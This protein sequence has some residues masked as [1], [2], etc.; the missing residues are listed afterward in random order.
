LVLGKSSWKNGYA[1]FFQKIRAA[2]QKMKLLENPEG[3]SKYRILE[4]PPL[5]ESYC[6]DKVRST[7]RN[8]S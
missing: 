2:S 8:A 1:R 7:V 3:I 5:I 6:V 4:E